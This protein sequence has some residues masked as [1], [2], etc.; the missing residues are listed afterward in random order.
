MV[1]FRLC[2]RRIFSVSSA[3]AS[4]S[5]RNCASPA[6]SSGSSTANRSAAPRAAV[7]I[8]VPEG[9]TKV[10]ERRVR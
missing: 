1:F 3:L 6:A 9:S 10:N 7:S 5:V 8:T 4:S 2:L